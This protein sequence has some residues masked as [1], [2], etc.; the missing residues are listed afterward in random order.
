M[1]LRPDPDPCTRSRSETS[2]Y[3]LLMRLLAIL[4]AA[5]IM[6]YA[7]SA[8][9]QEV[10]SARQEAVESTTSDELRRLYE[11]DQAERM[12]SPG[13]VIDF[14]SLMLRDEARQQQVKRLLES[15]AIRSGADYYHAAM[16]MQHA[17]DPDDHLLAH[18]LCVISLSK[19][20]QRAKWLAAA[21][22]DRF[23]IGIARP[24]QFGT[25][26]HSNHQ[27][28]PPKLSPVAPNMPDQLRREMGVP[29][30][31]EARANEAKMAKD[32]EAAK[33]VR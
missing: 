14:S 30:L 33:S 5:G 23:L 22:L 26:F 7:G 20:E 8:E 9:A 19:G 12:P 32:F 13:K 24:Q 15:G 4:T 25:Q 3:T 29:S 18:N 6:V 27:S 1:P 31:D 2:N 11:E 10:S 28:R 21:S 16:V 17:L